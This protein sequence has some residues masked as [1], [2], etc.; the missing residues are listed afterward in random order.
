MQRVPRFRAASL[1]VLLLSRVSFRLR[2]GPARAQAVNFS[3]AE[4]KLAQYLLVVLTDS[5]RALRGH[6]RDAMNL[7]GA[8]D[9]RSQLASGTLERNDDVVGAKL[10]IVDYFLRPTDGAERYTRATENLEPMRHWLRNERFVKNR[11]Q[12]RHVRHQLRWI[13]KTWISQKIGAADGFR[14][15]RNLVWSNDQNKPGVVL[16][17]IDVHCSVRGMRAIMKPEEFRIAERRLNGDTR[18]PYTLSEQRSR[19]MRALPGA[20]PAI[21]SGDDSRIEPDGGRIVAAAGH[22]P[23]RRRARIARHRE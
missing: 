14:D 19:D 4:S 20:L 8:A 7:N 18:R 12:L 11:G 23:G 22:R 13:G 1:P 6:F 2:N 16:G 5:R 21:E 15:G 10:R 3:G 17:M 9:R